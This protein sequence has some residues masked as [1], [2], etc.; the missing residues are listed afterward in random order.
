MWKDNRI[1]SNF[2]VSKDGNTIVFAAA[3]G[4]RPTDLYATSESMKTPRRLS[5]LNPQIDRKQLG[6]TELL[7]MTDSTA[8]QILYGNLGLHNCSLRYL[9]IEHFAPLRQVGITP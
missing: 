5:T 8:G 1:Y 7:G 3:E 6:K 2:R 9:A 4:N